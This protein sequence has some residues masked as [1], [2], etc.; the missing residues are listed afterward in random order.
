MSNVTK[1]RQPFLATAGITTGSAG[2][3]VAGILAGTVSACVIS[4]TTGASGAASAA[5]TGVKAGDLVWLTG[6]CT[7][8]SC[9][10]TGASVTANDSVVFKT[11]N[12]GGGTAAAS[13]ITLQYFVV[14][15]S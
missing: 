6:A 10:I 7:N 8:A 1:Q 12:S 11:Y 3:T 9:I 2:T 5:I 4:T 14:Q 15:T 13:T